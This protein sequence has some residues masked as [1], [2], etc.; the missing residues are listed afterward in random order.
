VSRLSTAEAERARTW[1]LAIAAVILGSGVPFEDVGHDRRWSGLGG[2]CVHRGCGAW[3]CHATGEGGYD[4]I[5]M[6][7]F[8]QRGSSW[9]DAE[10]WVLSFITAHPGNGPCVD[11]DDD[12]DDSQWRRPLNADRA[13]GILDKAGPI[14]GTDGERYL[15]SR[16]LGPAPYPLD[17]KWLLD[18]RTGEGAIVVELVA[19]GRTVAILITHVDAL[20][21]KSTVIPS[22]CRL[23]IEPN[24]PGAIIEIAAA[25]PG[26]TDIVADTI[27]CE[28]LEDGLSL[29]L[30]KSP[31]QRIVVLPG[32]GTLRHIPVGE[33]ERVIV[34]RDGDPSNSA[35][36]EALQAGID[37]LLLV[38]ARVRV[39]TTPLGADANSL[40]LEKGP[41]VLKR[42]LAK[43]EPATLSRSGEFARIA[44]LPLLDRG[45]EMRALSKRFDIPIKL[46]RQEVTKLAP[47]PEAAESSSA[48]GVLSVP[49]DPPWT[50]PVP[51]LGTLLDAI[52]TQLDRFIAMSST[53]ATA[54]TLWCAAAHLL[55]STFKDRAGKDCCIELF[56]KLAVQSK[57]PNSGKSSLLTLIWN[58][59]PRAKLWTYPSGAYLVRAIEIGNF[60]LCLDELQYAEDRNLLRVINASHQRSLAFVPLLVP[61]PDGGW[62]PVE[63][64]VWV[65]MAL[66]RLGEF[67][68]AQ[69]SR[70]IV[71]WM[72]P[73]LPS[74]PRERLRGA[75][76]P[77]LV[78]C[79]RQLAA[80]ANTV[81]TWVEP[82]LPAT[83]HNRDVNNWEPL[84]FVAEL[85]GGQWLGAAHEAINAQMKM[86][87]RPTQIQRLLSSIWKILQPDPDEDP[88]P[89]MRSVELLNKLIADEEGEW[90]TVNRG[91]AIT[92][93]WLRD[94]L[95]HLLNPPGSQNEYYT[96]ADGVR[97]HRRG[98]YFAQFKDAFARY[99]G[100]HPLS[101]GTPDQ[102]GAPGAPGASAKNSSKSAAPSAPGGAPG[103]ASPFQ[104]PV[105]DEPSKTAKKPISAPGA[106]GAPGHPGYPLEDIDGPGPA[107]ADGPSALEPAK[108]EQNGH[109]REAFSRQHA[110]D[111]TVIDTILAFIDENPDATAA[112][113]SKQLQI[114][115]STIKLVL[116]EWRPAP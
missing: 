41:A 25:T 61:N 34:F 62:T 45:P 111:P 42:L 37:A 30:V 52:R 54:V 16:G 114:K 17:L 90:G 70:S 84:L 32:I 76:V 100:V 57:D 109:D 36:A 35:A 58:I 71:N 12:D 65:P 3:Y 28:G 113:I 10:A 79:R 46:V 97:R 83:L 67:A 106:P 69:Q 104:H 4:T 102:P 9:T 11:V 86:E 44:R 6:V 74:E 82:V 105:H 49:E 75:I 50:G 99:V 115:P 7:R 56:P 24:Q 18:A 14:A 91:R 59:L 88:I 80:W 29:A 19:S 60:S 103:Q 22:R 5:G 112:Q 21:C 51:Q 63:F 78:E 110:I 89:F 96:D 20:G 77:E 85:A 47:K 8:L 66:A 23:N 1:N 27:I 81:T 98:Y 13:R 72:L 33:D 55:Q 107:A 87:R 15:I 95:A 116:A 53:Q 101:I 39:T 93:E 26:A 68:P 40:L 73:K 2:F 64:P 108:S 43:A 48:A 94:R 38:E 92:L 31:A